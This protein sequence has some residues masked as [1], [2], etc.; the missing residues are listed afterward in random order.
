MAK[1]HSSNDHRATEQ[2]CAYATAA[3]WSFKFWLW[4]KRIRT[5][6]LPARLYLLPVKGHFEVRPFYGKNLPDLVKTCS[7]KRG[8]KLEDIQH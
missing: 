4:S 5:K 6:A 7:F 8:V 3:G 2:D 1:E